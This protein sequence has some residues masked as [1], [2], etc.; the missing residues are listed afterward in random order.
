MVLAGVL[1]VAKLSCSRLHRWPAS[2]GLWLSCVRR[3]VGGRAGCR[4]ASWSPPPPG[5]PP[6]CAPKQRVCGC[7][8]VPQRSGQE[9]VVR[10]CR[11]T[12]SAVRSVPQA[13]VGRSRPSAPY[14][15]LCRRVCKERETV[16][17][18]SGCQKLGPVRRSRRGSPTRGASAPR[19]APRALHGGYL[20]DPASSHMLVSK[21]KPCMSKY[22]RLCTV[23]LRMAH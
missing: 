10:A 14:R 12:A 9:W 5:F 2:P 13:A 8:V 19:R 18:A 11:R 17:L 7:A 15:T 21:T 4:S 16:C 1:Q 6:H 20:V 3:G 23:K 22:K